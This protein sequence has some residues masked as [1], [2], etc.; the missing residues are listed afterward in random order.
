MDDGASTRSAFDNPMLLLWVAVGVALLFLA[1][2]VFD[3][4]RRRKRV[5]RSRRQREGFWSRLG[6]PLR[7]ARELGTELK[8][9]ERRRS[10]RKELEERNARKMR[11]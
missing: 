9:L 4:V 6:K 11:K 2:L 3:L 10:E 7:G 8:R 1:F 5:R